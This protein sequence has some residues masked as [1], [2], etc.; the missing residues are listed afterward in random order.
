MKL[1]GSRILITGAA[2]AIAAATARRLAAAGARLVLADRNIPALDKL[3]EELPAGTP[4]ACVVADLGGAA[5]CRVLA[6]EAGK[7]FG[8]IDV[9][10]NIAGLMDFTRFEN[11]DPAAIERLVQVNLVAPM[12][13]ARA[14]LPSLL[15]QGGGRI[16]NVGSTFGSIGFPYF[17]AYSAS[18][19]GMRGF[20]EALRRE[21]GGTGVGVTYIA[22]RATQTPFNTGA[23]VRMNRTL[24]VAMDPPE[25]VGAAI[26]RAIEAD[27]DEVHLG[28]PERLFVRLNGLFPRIVD[29]ALRKQQGV[30]RRFAA[31]R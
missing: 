21:L 24:K 15:A 12:L 8:G 11:A 2:G 30:M 14:L 23:I 25:L 13:L 29:G 3:H 1:A 16:V 19:F 22:P 27:R 20:S 31:E 28:W 9:L 17:A 10:V 26:Q 7:P 4:V 18:K 6:M 5:G